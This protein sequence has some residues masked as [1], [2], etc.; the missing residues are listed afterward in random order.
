[1]VAAQLSSLLAVAVRFTRSTTATRCHKVA[2][3]DHRAVDTTLA[4]RVDLGFGFG[5]PGVDPE[6][7]GAGFVPFFVSE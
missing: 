3:V 5:G 6:P 1:V 4:Q 7:A 2:V